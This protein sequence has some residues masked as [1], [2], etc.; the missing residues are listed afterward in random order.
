[1]ALLLQTVDTTKA[2]PLPGSLRLCSV[3]PRVSQP[4]DTLGKVDVYPM[5]VDKHALH[6]EVGPFAILL[7]RKLDEGVLEAVSGL[8]VPDDFAGE[9]LAEA[10]KDELQVLILGDW[11]QLAHEQDLLRRSDVGK[12]QIAYQLKSQGL[13][14][15]FPLSPQL[16]E[17]LWIRVFINLL[18][19]SDP[20]GGKLFL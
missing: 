2:A 12:G 18:I 19:M 16:L 1:M 5:V 10:G 17:R 3:P 9:N 8:L 6:F 13:S 20:H 4:A 7:G 14:T 11:V 15:R